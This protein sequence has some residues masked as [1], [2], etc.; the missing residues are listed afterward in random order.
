[1][2]DI[3]NIFSPQS[4]SEKEAFEKLVDEGQLCAYKHDGFWKS[5]NT[6]KDTLELNEIWN[7]KQAPWKIW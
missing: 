4:Q 5:M 1:M 7:K 3:D 2:S 6:F